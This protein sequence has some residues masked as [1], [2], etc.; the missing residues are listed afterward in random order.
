MTSE[1]VLEEVSKSS[2]HTVGYTDT[3]VGELR[4]IHVESIQAR[5][6]RNPGENGEAE[7]RC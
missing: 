4:D 3:E 2:R 5:N 1:S 7:G 6:G